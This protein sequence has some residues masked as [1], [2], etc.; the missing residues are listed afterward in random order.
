MADEH[1]DSNARHVARLVR[2]KMLPAAKVFP[3]SVTSPGYKPQPVP[4]LVVTVVPEAGDTAEMAGAAAQPLFLALRDHEIALGGAGLNFRPAEGAQGAATFW[5]RAVQPA[6][7]AD[8]LRA[9]AAAVTAPD[10]NG[11]R[12]EVER[13]A[14]RFRVDVAARN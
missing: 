9:V 1:D 5:V 2:V 13:L 10:G 11:V 14:G 8:R 12:R 4:G 3:P 6:G 7:A